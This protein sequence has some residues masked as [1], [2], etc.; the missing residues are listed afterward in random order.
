MVSRN[1][2]GLVVFMYG[3]KAIN[4]VFKKLVIIS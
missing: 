4:S 1:Q 2:R 3:E